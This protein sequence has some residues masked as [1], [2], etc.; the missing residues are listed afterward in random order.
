MKLGIIVDSCVGMMKDEIEKRGWHFLPLFFT[1]DG[2]EYKDG[3]DLN[4]PDFYEK[5]NINSQLKTS[6]SSSWETKTL[7]EKTSKMYDHVIV[8]CI[9]SGLSSQNNNLKIASREFSNIHVIDSKGVGSSIIHD[10][11]KIEKMNEEGHSI[12]K[13]LNKLKELTN[14]QIAF[15]LPNNITWL[16]KSGRVNKSVATMAKLFKIVPIIKFE[17]GK[18]EKY[19]KGRIFEKTVSKIARYIKE[20]SIDGSEFIIYYASKK[21]NPELIKRVEEVIGKKLESH[22]LP[23]VIGSHTG[24]DTFVIMTYKN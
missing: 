22:L 21:P 17:N 5:I 8:Y 2:K 6:A 10:L 16:V 7:F 20:E 4:L 23:I 24:N 11:E 13:M 12:E 18:L 1:I 19:G 9:S 3:I 15:I 14:A